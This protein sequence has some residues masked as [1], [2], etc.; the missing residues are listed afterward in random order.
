L[1][2][3][4]IAPAEVRP[5]RW[6]EF[7]SE[8]RQS[9]RSKE[10]SSS[11]E[12]AAPL[13]PTPD[14]LLEFARAEGERIVAAA[15]REAEGIRESARSQGFEK[16]LSEGRT[17]V[18]EAVERWEAL[19]R[20]LASAKPRLYEEGRVQV[21]ELAT[22]LVEKILGPLAEANAE[23]VVRVV[24]RALQAL[25]DREILTIRVNPGDLHALLEAKPHF[26]QTFDGI[27]K[28]TVLDDPAVPRGGCRV[29]TPTAE[30]DARL[31]SQLRELARNLKKA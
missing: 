14:E 30:V 28:L 4:R 23:A 17:A 29:E 22:A 18:A 21:V 9:S 8:E 12:P 6:T 3:R 10:E 24:G 1:G 5:F 13:C 19:A 2:A 20:E 15:A 11:P 7:A 31:D 16:G 25:S 27:K 26:L